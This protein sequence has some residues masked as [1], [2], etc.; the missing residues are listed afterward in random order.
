M[1]RKTIVIDGPIG[2]YSYSKQFIRHE[3]EGNQNNPV[4]ITLSSLGGDVDHA[5]NI[6]DQFVAHGD[7]TIELSAFVASSAT[8]ISLGAK[9]IR[10]NEN[11]FYLIHKVWQWVDEWG[12]MNEDEIEKVIDKL[13]KT[14]KDLATVTLQLARMY[15]KKTG[16]SLDQIIS[17]MKGERWIREQG[18]AIKDEYRNTRRPALPRNLTITKFAD[19]HFQLAKKVILENGGKEIKVNGKEGFEILD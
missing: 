7:V 3:L 19:L 18:W 12:G 9:H 6:Y 15:V 4:L 2:A 5:L 13:E 17:L 16:K 10:M 8:I 1:A 14:K 11:A